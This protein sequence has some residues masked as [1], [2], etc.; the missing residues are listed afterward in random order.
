MAAPSW[1]LSSAGRSVNF[2]QLLAAEHGQLAPGP[3]SRCTP[4][5]RAAPC[6]TGSGGRRPGR[7]GR[8]AGGRPW[9]PASRAA[10][11]R[12]RAACAPARRAPARC[13]AR[14]G[15]AAAAGFFAVGF[16]AAATNLPARI[17]STDCAQLVDGHGV[18]EPGVVQRVAE[19]LAQHARPVRRWRVTS[20]PPAAPGLFVVAS[21][22]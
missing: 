13:P 14:P 1:R 11:G 21:S 3:R 15:R 9:R 10:R 6:T 19:F 22:T 8:R 5:R 17:S 7:S 18:V 20:A 12:R 4:V 16:A 2:E